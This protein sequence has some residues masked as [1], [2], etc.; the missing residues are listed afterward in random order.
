[1]ILANSGQ[2]VKIGFVDRLQKSQIFFVGNTMIDTLMA[3]LSPPD[4]WDN[5]NLKHDHY[6]VVTMHRPANVDSVGAFAEILKAI[7]Q[8]TQGLPIVFP[9]HPRTTKTFKGIIDLPPNF[10]LVEPQPYLQFNYLVKHAKTV[11]TDSGGITEEATVMGVPCL[12]L[13]NN[14]KRPETVGEGTNELIGTNLAALGPALERIFNG[15]WK[16]G[17][18]PNLWDGMASER[19]VDQLEELLKKSQHSRGANAPSNQLCS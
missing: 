16:K 10:I 17:S 4:F 18:I 12:T 9:V 13:R 7:G 6:F 1:L 11:I 15:A 8:D 14:T 19:I 5:H 2:A 3:S